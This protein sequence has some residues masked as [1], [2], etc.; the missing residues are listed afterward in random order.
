VYV[1]GD[2]GPT[3]G[4]FEV[5]LDG[6]KTT[7]SAYAPDAVKD[8][9]KPHLLFGKG[10]LAYAPHTLV[11]RNL[12]KTGDDKG[13]DAF[14]LDFLRTTVQLAPAGCVVLLLHICEDGS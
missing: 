9:E 4:S 2:A 7:L 6:T 10:D 8:S 3:Y 14:L 1:Y 12:G 13:G 11:L 5:E